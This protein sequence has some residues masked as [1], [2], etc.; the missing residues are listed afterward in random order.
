LSKS[1]VSIV[2]LLGSYDKST[3][4]VLDNIK[5]EIARI[6]SGK[7]F[8]FVLST[9]EIYFTK[10]FEIL[11]EIEQNKQITLFLFEG[12]NLYDVEDLPLEPDKEPSEVAYAFLKNKFGIYKIKKQPTIA[13][14]NFL[15]N[16]AKEIFL[17]R[18]EELTRGGEYVELM[19]ALFSDEANKI[20]FFSKKSLT[21]SSMLMEYLD[22]FRVKMR[23]YTGLPDLKKGIVRIVDYLISAEQ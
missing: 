22:M 4:S 20:W 16:L 12:A 15:M 3:K 13:K 14:Y 18:E 10:R 11:A 5:E 7:I 2:L 6:F 8:A 19:H 9:L 1:A 17:I 23:S 21:I